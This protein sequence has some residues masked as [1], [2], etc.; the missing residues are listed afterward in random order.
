M[1]KRTTNQI[2]VS[3]EWS[4]HIRQMARYHKTTMSKAMDIM[5][6]QHFQNFNYFAEYI[7]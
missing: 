2:R 4:P 7:S 1:K 6:K 3:K 5:C